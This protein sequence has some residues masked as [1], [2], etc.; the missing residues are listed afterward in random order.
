M[1]KAQNQESEHQNYKASQTP[2]KTEGRIVNQIIVLLPSNVP[3][4]PTHKFPK[5]HDIWWKH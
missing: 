5:K 2:N 3:F 1:V 4:S